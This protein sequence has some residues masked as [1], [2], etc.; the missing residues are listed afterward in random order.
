MRAVAVPKASLEALSERLR[1]T[2]RA[3]EFV[4]GVGERLRPELCEQ[5][6]DL[7][8]G[9]KLVWSLLTGPERDAV[10]QLMLF[11]APCTVEEAEATVVLEAG[12]PAVLDVL[13]ALVRAG[14]VSQ[15][16]HTPAGSPRFVLEDELKAFV[17]ARSLPTPS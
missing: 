1:P 5:A 7:T 13:E 15:R 6:T 9:L 12:G 3:L 17:A 14:L 4:A 2:P 10:S 8:T 16:G 11:T